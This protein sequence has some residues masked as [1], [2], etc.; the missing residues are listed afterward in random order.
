MSKTAKRKPRN[1][2][3]TFKVICEGDTEYNYVEAFR[4]KYHDSALKI[5]I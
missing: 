2:N 4:K 1:L 5:T 3:Y